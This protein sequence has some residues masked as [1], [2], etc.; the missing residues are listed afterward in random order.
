MNIAYLL[1]GS[2]LLNPE[3]QVNTALQLIRSYCGKILLSSALYGSEPWG[4]TD[5]P[6]FVN[7]AI[8]VETH[9]SAKELL[10]K[11]LAI[12][13]EMGRERVIKMGPRIIDIDI[14]L[15][16]HAV[17]HE[18]GLSVPHPLLTQRR[19]ALLPL[20]EIASEYVH[21]EQAKKISTLLGSCKDP[22]NVYKIN[23]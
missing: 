4:I 23:S 14:L 9:F 12:E 22:L 2:N 18:P 11:I 13:K 10:Q 8:C 3:M 6:P 15:F 19:F 17:I 5:Q 21:P 7:Q 16:N 1:T 20:A